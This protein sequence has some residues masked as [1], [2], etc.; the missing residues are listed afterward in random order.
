[1][2]ERRENPRVTVELWVEESLGKEVYFQRASNLSTGGLFLEGTLPHA[3]GTVVRLRFSLPG[4]TE[5]IET[6]GEIVN[7]PGEEGRGMGLQF[8]G[9]SD[10]D[11][12]RIARF[13]TEE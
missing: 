5:V 11:H 4:E 13:V 10:A 9:L 8:V 7:V 1:M 2:S 6:R 12:A 3:P